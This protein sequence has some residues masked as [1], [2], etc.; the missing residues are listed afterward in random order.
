MFLGNLLTEISKPLRLKLGDRFFYD[1][2]LN[3]ETKFTERQLQQIRKTSMARVICDNTDTV[4]RIQPQA[5]KL[6]GSSRA[7]VEHS[8]RSINIPSVNLG[9][10][11]E[12]RQRV[13]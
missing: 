12:R 10:W 8:C 11:R 9:P 4:F 5:F 13:G 7:N 2:G 1:L 6:P 3:D